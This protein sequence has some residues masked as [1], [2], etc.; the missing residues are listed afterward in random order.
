MINVHRHNIFI[1]TLQYKNSLFTHFLAL[2]P[3]M[4]DFNLNV[5]WSLLNLELIVLFPKTYHHFKHFFKYYFPSSSS[6][7]M[8][9]G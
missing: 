6:F 7:K 9:F 2:T 1:F 8:F 4:T 3:S 5:E